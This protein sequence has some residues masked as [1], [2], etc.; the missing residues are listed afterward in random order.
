MDSTAQQRR[1]TPPPHQ[2]RVVEFFSGIGGWHAGFCQAINEII[3]TDPT[4]IDFRVVACFD[5]NPNANTVYAANHPHVSVVTSDLKRLTVKKL[6]KYR[7]NVW[8][9][10]PPCQPHTRNGKKGDRNDPRSAGFHNLLKILRETQQPPEIILMENVEGFE[11]SLSHAALLEAVRDAQCHY[12][13][14]EYILSPTQFGVPNQRDR[15]Y[16]LAW[17]GRGDSDASANVC[18]GGGGGGGGGAAAADDDDDDARLR[19]SAGTSAGAGA[20]A[21]ASASASASASA[22][23]GATGTP[24]T[25]SSA[26]RVIAAAASG[27]LQ[28]D[29]GST[30]EIV[31]PYDINGRRLS[32]L[33]KSV[34]ALPVERG[35]LR[36]GR[37]KGKRKATDARAE[38]AATGGGASN[39]GMKLGVGA[40]RAST[41]NNYTLQDLV[42]MEREGGDDDDMD[43][44]YFKSV[45]QVGGW[46]LTR[47]LCP[48]T[49]SLVHCCP[50]RV[51][52]GCLVGVPAG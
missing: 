2:L 51:S 45:V 28:D 29:E 25:S 7:A 24:A 44:N 46:I 15:Y 38:H 1:C 27:Q 18:T 36:S 13:C 26:H 19:S 20:G 11:N 41:D 6:N 37:G 5:V 43:S 4:S 21:G 34:S 12:H 3:R 40:T 16:F 50:C 49:C 48:V 14:E 8:A 30:V 52:P 39:G 17:R 33:T 42:R 47:S 22:C 9:M 31:A 32:S 35:D 10:S 23:A